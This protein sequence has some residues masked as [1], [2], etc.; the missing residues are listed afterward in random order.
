[1]ARLIM[2]LSDEASALAEKHALELGY[3][4]AADYAFELLRN[5]VAQR[6]DELYTRMH[7]GE[8]NP[9]FGRSARE[10]ADFDRRK[11][12]EQAGE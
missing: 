9:V 7:A 6:E 2:E 10:Q 12:A 5:Y 11:A 1:M 3:P 4:N 8:L